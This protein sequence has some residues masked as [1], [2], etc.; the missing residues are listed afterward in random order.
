MRQA[1]AK[2]VQKTK[3]I[4]DQKWAKDSHADEQ[5]PTS[6][7]QIAAVEINGIKLSRFDDYVNPAYKSL[8]RLLGD[9]VPSERYEAMNPNFL[10]N[11]IF[12]KTGTPRVLD[13]GCGSGRSKGMF[14]EINN[15]TKWSGIE[16]KESYNISDLQNLP[17]GVSIYDGVNIPFDDS[18][19]DY[20]YSKQVFEH[21]RYP[22]LLLNEINRVLKPGGI[23]FGSLSGGEPYHWHSL[24]NFT[25]LGWKTV[26]EDHGFTLEKLYSG[27]DALSL[28]LHHWSV[29]RKDM[30][31]YF[32]NSILNSVLNG[33]PAK[34]TPGIRYENTL[35]LVFAG[36]LVFLATKK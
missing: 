36:H 14:N 21:V 16:I 15:E 22:E 8:V 4:I 33:E 13:I 6:V 17:E 28:L 10:A 24:F 12:S 1:L 32:R 31:P 25:P 27:I 34:T 9:S 29:N 20:C 11:E 18:Y 23:F 2:L 19:F 3:P 30:G 35:K 26:V 5:D 7:D